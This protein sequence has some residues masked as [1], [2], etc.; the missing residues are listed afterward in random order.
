MM[1][2]IILLSRYFLTPFDKYNEIVPGIWLGNL[3]ACYDNNFL[4]NQNIVAIVSLYTP[5]LNAKKLTNKGIAIFHLKISDNIGLKTN[6]ILLDNFENIYNF[7]SKYK[8]KGNILIHCHYGWQRSASVCTGY[9]MREYKLSKDSA[10]SIVQSKRKFALFPES[11]FDLAL[12]MYE[13]RL[14]NI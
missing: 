9:L 7:I 2:N 4:E 11:S 13:K 6:L 5:I 3:Q 12:R 8:K 10:I 14:K 1:E